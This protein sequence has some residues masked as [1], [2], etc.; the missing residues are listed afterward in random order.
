MEAS[1]KK[2]K[3]PP[4][5]NALA[6]V[7]VAALAKE[8]LK[9]SGNRNPPTVKYLGDGQYLGIEHLGGNT[10]EVSFTDKYSTKIKK[11]KMNRGNDKI[12][13]YTNHKFEFKW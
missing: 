7:G 4:A 13:P 11:A 12:M 10:W 9:K 2:A 5:T 1:Q 3:T 8:T 6:L